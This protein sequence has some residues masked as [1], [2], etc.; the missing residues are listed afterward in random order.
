MINAYGMAKNSYVASPPF[1]GCHYD[2]KLG[3]LYP[4]VHAAFGVYLPVC[5]IGISYVTIFVSVY[6][7][8]QRAVN[9]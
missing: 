7:R 3:D 6:V 5:I 9:P 1:G 8:R 2:S 4:L